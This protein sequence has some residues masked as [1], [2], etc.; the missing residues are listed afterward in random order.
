MG[1]QMGPGG[2]SAGGRRRR[3]RRAQ[4]ISEINVTP[5]VDVM[6]V[7]LIV[8]MVAAPLLTVGVP[9]DL[10]ETRATALEGD[11]EPITISVR[12]DGTVFIQDTEIAMDEVVPKLE[13]IA[14]N[15][16]DERIYVRGDQNSD[17]GTMMRLMGRINAA[18]FKR[19]GL[20]TLEEQD[21]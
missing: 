9:I 17:Y 12:S 6:L 2:G 15:G 8:F 16:Y 20:V 14:Q 13:A 21:S 19:L 5:F 1:M 7:L 4:P 18:G 3:R 11:T 10:P